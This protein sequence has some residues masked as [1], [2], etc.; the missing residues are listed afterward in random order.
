MTKKYNKKDMQWLKA[1][2][3]NPDK[4]GDRALNVQ[5]KIFKGA[6]DKS[7]QEDL[8]QPSIFN[9]DLKEKIKSNL[10]K[11]GLYGDPSPNFITKWIKEKIEIIRL[12]I[13][14]S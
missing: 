7:H 13:K 11:E 5:A 3:G 12:Y 6:L 14:N 1:L 2:S 9:D 8:T 4:K 10:I